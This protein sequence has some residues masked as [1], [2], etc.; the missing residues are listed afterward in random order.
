VAHLPSGT[1]TFLFAD[2]EGSTRLLERVGERYA[3]ILADYRRVLRSAVEAHGGIE[4]DTQGDGVFA[5]FPRARDALGAAI[6]AQRALIEHRWPAEAAVRARMGLHT[7]EPV[8]SE[9]G[10]VGMDVHRAARISAVAHGGQ[11][12]LSETTRNPVE[13]DL[14]D[15]VSLTELGDHVLKDLSRP[16]RLFQLLARG[17]PSSFPPLRSI[18]VTA[19]PPTREAALPAAPGP[20]IGRGHEVSKL[21][22]LIGHPEI[23]LL[24]LTGPPGI[25]KTRIALE[26]AAGVAG[27][28]EDG[29]RYIES[30]ISIS[31][32][33][34]TPTSS[35][36]L[37]FPADG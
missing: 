31:P 28:F 2:L 8:T 18:D 26:T 11:V 9:T 20:L 34:P 35:R 37:C 22:E 23:R 3:R 30:G 29:V 13:A 33:R 32:R 5:A 4:V 27:H 36:L 1:V 16:Q 17:L 12:I 15:E 10:Y 6:A 24:T 7:G 21:R 25:G 19:Q 14:P